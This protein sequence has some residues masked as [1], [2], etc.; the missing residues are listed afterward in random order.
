MPLFYKSKWWHFW[1]VSQHLLKKYFENYS[2]CWYFHWWQSPILTDGGSYLSS[3]DN[4]SCVRI[5]TSLLSVS[6]ICSPLTDWT[7]CC[8]PWWAYDH[9]MYLISFRS[10][11]AWTW[12]LSKLTFE[13]SKQPRRS[14]NRSSPCHSKEE[15]LI[16]RTSLDPVFLFSFQHGGSCERWGGQWWSYW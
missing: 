5:S 1:I 4:F 16:L 2:H 7:R 3:N 12:P 14:A 13:E 11:A 15:S 8:V 9:N 10:F 6:K